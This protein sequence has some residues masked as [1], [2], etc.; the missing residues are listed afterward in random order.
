MERRYTDSELAEILAGASKRQA[1]GGQDGWSVEQVMAM[2]AE[3][4]IDSE[5]VR[6]ELA[7]FATASEPSAGATETIP[8]PRLEIGGPKGLTLR[9]RMRGELPTIAIED[10]A[11]DARRS[12][13]K[14][15]RLESR[16]DELLVEGSIDGADAEFSVESGTKYSTM[17][18]TLRFTRIGRWIHGVTQSLVAVYV[19]IN[20]T[21]SWISYWQITWFVL[22]VIGFLAGTGLTLLVAR[23]ARAKAEKGFEL[24]ANRAARMLSA[25][26]TAVSGVEPSKQETSD[27]QLDH[28]L[29][30]GH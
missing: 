2:A 23:S 24:Q 5:S 18:L 3:I 1:G 9:R 11:E 26:A 14:I 28:R 21:N 27:Q 30:H 12:F 15:R 29:Q 19:V 22:A 25:T 17:S 16:N 8:D 7:Q 20:S 13:S 6:R 10:A 4:G